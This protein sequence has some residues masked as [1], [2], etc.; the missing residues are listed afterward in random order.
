[1]ISMTI[2]RFNIFG[3]SDNLIEAETWAIDKEK[4]LDKIKNYQF[5]EIRRKDLKTVYEF[6]SIEFLEELEKKNHLSRCEYIIEQ[7]KEYARL[8]SRELKEYDSEKSLKVKEVLG[9][10]IDGINI[11]FDVL[12]IRTRE[13]CQ[14]FA[15]RLNQHF[16]GDKKLTYDEIVKY[17]KLEGV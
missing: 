3:R 5:T 1:M 8:L 11:A 4:A 7:R 17:M 2:F 13:E 10:T 12:E 16:N 9:K 15:V 14:W 6:D